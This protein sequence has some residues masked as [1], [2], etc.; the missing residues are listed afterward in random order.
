MYVWN[1]QSYDSAECDVV[2]V[3]QLFMT[4]I[5]CWFAT[6]LTVE[7]LQHFNTNGGILI[8]LQLF[9]NYV[10]YNFNSFIRLLKTIIIVI[11]VMSSDQHCEMHLSNC[12]F[13][14]LI[15]IGCSQYLL[16]TLAEHFVCWFISGTLRSRNKTLIINA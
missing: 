15:V 14:I 1:S 8:L 5:L 6:G 7:A 3:I 2:R 9:H 4:R 12:E 13:N 11:T 10:I 16:L